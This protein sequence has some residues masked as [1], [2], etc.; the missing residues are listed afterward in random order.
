MT[1]ITIKLYGL[2][3]SSLGINNLEIEAENIDEVLMK[4]DE[5]FGSQFECFLKK[6]GLKTMGKLKDNSVVLVNGVNLRNLKDTRLKPDDV[7]DIFPPIG[8]G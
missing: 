7:I 6:R 3:Q 5:M 1:N 4:L 2:W 8:G